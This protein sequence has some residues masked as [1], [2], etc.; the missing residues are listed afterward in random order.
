M[1]V[2]FIH[3]VVGTGH[4]SGMDDL[5]IV[6]CEPKPWVGLLQAYFMELDDRAV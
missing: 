2:T 1:F 4:Q 6:G 5:E 3:P